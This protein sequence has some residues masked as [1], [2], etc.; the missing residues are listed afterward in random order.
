M[1]KFAGGSTYNFGLGV[2]G[3]TN[4]FFIPEIYSKKVQ[5]ALRKAAVAEAVC[6]T[7]YMGEI[8][9]FGDTVNI[10]K[11]P[12]IAVADYT[13][14]LAVTSTD[15][16]DQELVLTVDQAKSFSFKI[17]DLEKRFSHVNFQAIAADNAAYALRDA[18]DSNILAA[19]SAGATATTGMGTTSTPIDIGFG[20][21]EVDPLNQMALAA[22]ELDEANAPEDGRWFVAAPEWYNQLS[23]SASKLLSVDFNAGQGSIRNGLVASGLLRGF[24]MYKSN[25]LPTNDL[26]GAT[27]A[28]SATAP[29]ALFGHMSSTAAASSMNKVETVRDTGTFSDI[30]RGLMVWGRKVLRPEV[31]GKIIYAID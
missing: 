7:D 14:G 12:Q 16:T 31:A 8:S 1:A 13:R 2:S 30:V 21:G 28:G 17:D 10:I 3:Q 22:K 4:G 19:I 23:N 24:S 26:S 18:M 11:E 5:I 20:S 9:S 6:N 27:P 25:N 29:E 15:L